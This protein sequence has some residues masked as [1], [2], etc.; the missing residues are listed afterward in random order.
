M[1]APA[2]GTAGETLA[3]D[4][5]VPPSVMAATEAISSRPL[6]AMRRTFV[7]LE[8]RDFRFLTAGTIATGFGQWGL[9]IGT[10]WLVYVLTGSAVQLGTVAFVSGVAALLLTPFGGVIA[11]RYPRRHLIL[12]VTVFSAM[13]AGVAATLVL[14][15]VIQVWHAYVLAILT[16]VSMAMSQPVRQ[17]YVFDIS[18]PETVQNAIT[19]T[20]LAQNLSRIAGPTLAGALIGGAGTAAPFVFVSIMMGIAVIATLPL[21]AVT[22]QETAARGN[23]LRSLWQGFQYAAADRRILGL[24][25]VN[26]LPAFL[27]Y[28]YLQFLP[29]FAKDVLHAGAGAYG[30]LASMIGVGSATGL[31]VL[32]IVGT[33]RHMGRWMLGGFLLYFTL[34]LGFTQS[35]VL[36]VSLG[37]LI[38]AGMCHGFAMAINVTMFQTS[39][40]SDMR[41]RAMGIWQ[42]GFAV[43]P[44]GALPLGVLVD[45][46]GVQTAIAI[47]VSVCLA[48]FAV[49]TVTWRSVRE[50]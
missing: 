49:L 13:H 45:S 27:V 11:D 39:V 50:F 16:S 10:N 32:A 8:D 26:T 38:G 33:V 40:R 23:P 42:M 37:L 22:Q 47:F 1:A 46:L 31:L 17:A 30:L 2:E 4:S 43:M 29:V 28:P 48:L 18:R 24:L 14:T 20:S 35:D 44:M 6:S 12:I 34:I 36:A 7:S 21:S 9:T 15:D 41:G 19:L 25:V 3:L 5:A